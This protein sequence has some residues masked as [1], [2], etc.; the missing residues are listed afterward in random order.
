V[1][2]GVVLSCEQLE[3]R[4]SMFGMRMGLV[5]DEDGRDMIG[6]VVTRMRQDMGPGSMMCNEV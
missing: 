3:L 6:D 5:G 4:I 2:F 1:V